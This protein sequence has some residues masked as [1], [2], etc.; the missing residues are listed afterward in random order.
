MYFTGLSLINFRNYRSLD[1]ALPK[2][3]VV[4]HGANAQG[5]SNFL[6]AAYLVSIA[7]SYNV[8]QERELIHHNALISGEPAVITAEAEASSGHIQ[9]RMV[10]QA[11]DRGVE[12]QIRVNG[13]PCLASELV[14]QV[15]AVLFTASDLDLVYGAPS[16]RRRFLDILISQVDRAYLRTLQRYQRVLS[17]RNH[18]LRMV[19]DISSKEEELAFWDMELIKEGTV[20]TDKRHAVI[21]DLSRLA[22]ELYQELAPDYNLNISYIPS[23]GLSESYEERLDEVRGKEIALGVTLVGPHRDDLGVVVNDVDM[24]TYASRGEARTIAL[25]LRLAEASFLRNER[26]EEPVLLLDDILSELDS[27]RRKL[28]V[29]KLCL[30]EQALL[31]T[32]DLSLL[33]SG[34]LE[35]MTRFQVSGGIIST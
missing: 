18:L 21:S 1:L 7:K 3:P 24:G 12:K 22:S 28:V 34:A 13:L 16:S 26:G 15:N 30:Q 33:D 8:H 32:T 20:I 35:Q 11:K 29:E 2:G 5:K 23:V 19:K 17:Q 31:T 25:A 6:E 27:Y 14:G 4:I 10:L 9:T